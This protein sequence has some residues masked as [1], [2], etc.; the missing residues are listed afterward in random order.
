MNGRRTWLDRIEAE[1]RSALT[2]GRDPPDAAMNSRY[3]ALWLG[4]STKTLLMLRKRGIVPA[5]AVPS[6]IPG[7]FAWRYLMSDLD[8]F[9][10][11]HRNAKRYWDTEEDPEL[12]VRV[13]AQILAITPGTV[14]VLK[15]RGKLTDYRTESVRAYPEKSYKRRLSRKFTAQAKS[16]VSKLRLE[17]RRLQERLC[18]NSDHVHNRDRDLEPVGADQG[19]PAEHSA[20]LDCTWPRF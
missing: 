13:V 11:T 10:L 2:D 7:K 6:K 14:S 19:S 17:V 18:T 12:P 4:I 16:K 1:I 5:F 9:K 8:E 3:A 20:S 15:S